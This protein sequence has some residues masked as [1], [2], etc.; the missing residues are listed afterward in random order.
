MAR[1]IDEAWVEE[2]IS[3]YRRIEALQAEFDAAVQKTE[4]TA[5]SPDGLVEVSAN[6]AG[7]VRKVTIVGSLPGRSNVDV[8]RS[9]ESAIAAAAEA[10]EW[11]RRSLY[12]ET[13]G[14]YPPLRRP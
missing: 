14:G 11:T 10:A 8:S 6:A 9:I 4:V 1:E 13:F 7:A 12:A 3:R 2:A 5:R